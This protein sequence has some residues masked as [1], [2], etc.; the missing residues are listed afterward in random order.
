MPSLGGSQAADAG[1]HAD[2]CGGGPLSPD[3]TGQLNFLRQGVSPS[4]AEQQQQRHICRAASHATGPGKG[5]GE[6]GVYGGA[7]EPVERSGG[8]TEEELAIYAPRFDWTKARCGDRSRDQ[9]AGLSLVRLFK[10][11]IS[12]SFF[13]S[14]SVLVFP[15]A[16]FPWCELS[17]VRQGAARHVGVPGKHVPRALAILAP[18]L[19][20]K[21]ARRA[22]NASV[23]GSLARRAPSCMRSPSSSPCVDDGLPLF[24]CLRLVPR[25]GRSSSS[26]RRAPRTHRGKWDAAGVGA[27]AREAKATRGWRLRKG[28]QPA[29]E[30]GW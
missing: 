18:A 19:A 6:S 2:A 14:L 23:F 20:W 3:F 22:T 16:G 17:G 28:R 12:F 27:L 24:L 1:L 15:P 21:H 11:L 26:V 5:E 30:R 25:V 4:P 13:P 29:S 8:P 9:R 10:V 7:V